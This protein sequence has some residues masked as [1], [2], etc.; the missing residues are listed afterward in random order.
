MC[1]KPHRPGP[2]SSTCILH[3][4][5]FWSNL[6]HAKR[7]EFFD[8]GFGSLY[9]DYFKNFMWQGSSR[10][11]EPLDPSGE[12]TSFAAFDRSGREIVVFYGLW[13]SNSWLHLHTQGFQQ[14]FNKGFIYLIN[15]KWIYEAEAKIPIQSSQRNKK[16]LNFD[17]FLYSE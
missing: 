5:S 9:E 14:P 13:C 2:H 15:N 11:Y 8:F 12:Y 4:H 1:G 10:P 17:F 6:W 16:N 3:I 7:L